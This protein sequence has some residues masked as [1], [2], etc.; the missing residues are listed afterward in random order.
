MR[1]LFLLDSAWI[2]MNLTTTDLQSEL[3]RKL[4]AHYSVLLTK[5][6]RTLEKESLTAEQT[7]SIR[8][9]IKQLRA[10]MRPHD[11]ETNNQ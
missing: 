9:A 11:Y 7:A 1:A 5:H 6:L 3:W 2:K 10:L 8:G 4:M